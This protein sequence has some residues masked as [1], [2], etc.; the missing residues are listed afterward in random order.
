MLDTGFMLVY[1]DDPAKSAGFYA[2]LLDRP[3]KIGSPN[4]ASISLASGFTLAFWSKQVAS[5]KPDFSGS[6][7][8]LL[9]FVD[10]PDDLERVH[11]RWRDEER[12]PILQAPTDL[13]FGRTFVASDP[14]GHR[15]RVIAPNETGRGR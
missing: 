11:V 2:R 14:D 13:V 1:V 6:S 3:S 12:I 9:L 5:P 7:G 10:T 15:V 8:E 4:F